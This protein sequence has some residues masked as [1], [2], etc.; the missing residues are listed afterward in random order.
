MIEVR[1]S[2]YPSRSRYREGGGYWREESEGAPCR[3]RNALRLDP[4][5]GDMG[6]HTSKKIHQLYT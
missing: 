5:D 6:V 4:S 1:N 2:G 3:A